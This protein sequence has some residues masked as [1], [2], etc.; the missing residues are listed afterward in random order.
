LWEISEYNGQDVC[1][2]LPLLPEEK[3]ML[4]LQHERVEVIKK[5]RQ[6]H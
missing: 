1:R 6:Q 5:W 2:D 4:E 3:V